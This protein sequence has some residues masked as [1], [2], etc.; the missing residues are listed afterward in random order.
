L[1]VTHQ[2]RLLPL[3]YLLPE[4]GLTFGRESIGQAHLLYRSLEAQTAK[5][6]DP[7][8]NIT[9]LEVRSTGSQTHDSTFN[10]SYGVKR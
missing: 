2:K 9:I 3:G 4:T 6:Q 8:G 1:I 5:F 7:V 10:P